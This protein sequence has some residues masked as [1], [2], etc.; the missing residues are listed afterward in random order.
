MQLQLQVCN[1][2]EAIQK[3]AVTPAS[4]MVELLSLAKDQQKLSVLASTR[5]FFNRY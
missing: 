1:F 5:P 2:L 4:G 3:L